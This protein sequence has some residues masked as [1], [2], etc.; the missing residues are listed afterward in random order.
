MTKDNVPLDSIWRNGGARYKVVGVTDTHVALR[1]LD[2]GRQHRVGL[3]RY[4]FKY[5]PVVTD[6]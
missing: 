3:A 4:Q 2:T 5:K 1:S 6:E